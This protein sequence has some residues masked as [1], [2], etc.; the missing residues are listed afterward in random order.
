M[1]KKII[2]KSRAISS[3]VSIVILVAIMT[4]IASAIYIYMS[5]TGRTTPTVTVILDLEY[6]NETHELVII[7][8]GG[9][10]ITD[11]I[12]YN[13]GEGENATWDN[14]EVRINGEL[15][16]EEGNG[17]NDIEPLNET[18]IFSYG[19]EVIIK[20]DGTTKPES[21]DII[22]VTYTPRGQLL[23]NKELSFLD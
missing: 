10:T 12:T 22:A 5:G 13:A 2:K 17:K 14:L 7:H 1:H 4:A 11:A 16:S 9:D 21:G 3:V 23:I 6:D 20:F 19:T 15:L 18:V 8:T